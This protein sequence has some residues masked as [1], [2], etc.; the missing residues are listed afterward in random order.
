M[1]FDDSSNISLIRNTY[2][3]LPMQRDFI[4]RL[5]VHLSKMILGF[6]DASSLVNCVCVSNHWRFLAEEVM[7][8]TLTQQIMREDVMLIQVGMST[9]FNWF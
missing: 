2:R 7:N 6:L 5:P 9:G 3:S 4:R 8:E 1:S